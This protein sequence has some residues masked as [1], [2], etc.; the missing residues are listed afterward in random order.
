[1]SNILQRLTPEELLEVAEFL[2]SKNVTVSRF[3]FNELASAPFGS[4][5]IFDWD[6]VP[7]Y[8]KRVKDVQVS[9]QSYIS[10][11]R[12]SLPFTIR[13]KKF[14]DDSPYADKILLRKVEKT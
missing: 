10:T 13:M 2:G 11:H 8:V 5:V 3:I 9:L 4:C 6:I 1:M 12:G 7:A 14:K